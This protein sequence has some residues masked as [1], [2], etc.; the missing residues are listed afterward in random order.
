MSDK[1][2]LLV[3]GR[4]DVIAFKLLLKRLFLEPEVSVFSAEL[5]QLEEIEEL[6][7]GKSSG[8]GVGNRQKVERICR[9]INGTNVNRSS[10]Q[11]EVVGFIDRDFNGFDWIDGFADYVGKHRVIREINLVWSRG[12][13]LENYVFDIAILGEAFDGYTEYFDET[14]K[15][16]ARHFEDTIRLACAATLAGIASN[17]NLKMIQDSIDWELFKIT[18]TKIELDTDIWSNHLQRRFSVTSNQ[19][20]ELVSLYKTWQPKVK[21]CVFDIIRWFCHGH[22]GFTF[23]VEMY[24]RC[25]FEICA[26][27]GEEE[28]K[29]QFNRVR[30]FG[31]QNKWNDCVKSWCRKTQTNTTVYPQ[32]VFQLLHLPEQSLIHQTH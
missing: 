19:A 3:E 6:A 26:S 10:R 9:I 20:Q 2:R 25:V 16:F 1:R 7:D 23:I 22:I 28:Q 4:D 27:L 29:R 32:E 12:H 18:D 5:V 11:G 13:S 8:E 24:T 14:L 17:N 15:L 31:Y 21:E 30:K